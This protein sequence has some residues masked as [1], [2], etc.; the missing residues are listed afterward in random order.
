MSYMKVAI[1]FLA[2]LFLIGG[3]ACIGMFF[4]FGSVDALGGA[5]MFLCF[6]LALGL[7]GYFFDQIIGNKSGGQRT[8]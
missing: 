8:A 2:G 1:Y 6:G 5:V 3:A 4:M 7:F